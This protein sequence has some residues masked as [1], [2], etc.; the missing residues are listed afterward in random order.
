MPPSYTSRF[1]EICWANGGVG[2]GWWPGC[3]YDPRLTEPRTRLRARKHVGKKHLV[4]FFQCHETPFDLLSSDKI[5]TW[6]EGLAEGLYQGRA[7]KAVGRKRYGRFQEALQAAC[8]EEGK[9]ISRRLD[10]T[11]NDAHP[12]TRLL[13]SPVQITPGKKKRSRS[14]NRNSRSG[15]QTR[16]PAR[17]TLNFGNGAGPVA[18]SGALEDSIPKGG[19]RAPPA[20]ATSSEAM[21]MDTD[22]GSSSELYCQV[23]L[24]QELGEMGKIVGFVM[25]PSPSCTFADMRKAIVETLETEKFPPE[26]RFLH[27]I[28]GPVSIKLEEKVG[29]MIS[30]LRKGP[31]GKEVG[32]GS[33]EDPA[34]VTIM[35]DPLS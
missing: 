22:D 29:S 20:A 26:W 13:P 15:T 8:I 23:Y 10:W 17:R 4:Y 19:H 21:V 30:Y 11:Q 33:M 18:D 32:T 2:Y 12:H 1:G 31:K 34:K 5:M 28:L 35:A 14:S 27:P 6:E 3:I 25:L 9:P 7:A 16:S 24:T